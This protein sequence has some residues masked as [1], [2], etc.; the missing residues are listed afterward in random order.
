MFQQNMPREH[1]RILLC[2]FT[3]FTSLVV[4]VEE[5]QRSDECAD[6][7]NP[8]WQDRRQHRVKLQVQYLL[9]TR[10]NM[11]CAQMFSRESLT[12]TQQQQK[13]YFNV[14]R[15]TKVI[16]H[17]YRALGSKPSWLMQLVHSVLWA[18]DVN[19][20]VVDWI[21]GASFAYNLVVENYKDVALQISVLIN[22]L[23]EHGCKLESFHF[24]GVS[25]GAHVAGFVG[26]LFEGK[27]GRITALDPAGP[28][29]K[30]ADTFDRLDSS[31]ALFVD[32]IHTDSDYFGIS[33]P[34]GHL[35]F[36][37]NGGE[38]DQTG[39]SRSRFA[40]I[41]VYFP[42]YG[43]VICDH[44]R[45]LHVYISALNSSCPLIG[46]P[47]SSYED[48]LK[49]RCLDCDVFKGRCPTIGLSKNSGIS[50][51]PVP[52]EQKLFLLT[53]S[54]APFCSHHFLL[55]L[56]VSPLDKSAEVEVTL[57]TGNLGTEKRFRLQ[58]DTTVYRLVLSHPVALCEIDSIKLKNTGNRFYRQSE[59]HVRSVCLSEFP[60]LRREEP[61]CVNNINVRR[62]APW[63]HDFVQVCGVF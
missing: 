20:V 18:E 45:A 44:M 22:Q 62:G 1:L 39:C 48:F 63:S 17:G 58:T 5:T 30:G 31:D 34:V 40:S 29:F 6:L 52:K 11:D 7:N 27:I 54:S 32:A 24:I 21:Y 41:L 3:V 23:Q 12:E 28:M 26:T 25:L 59:V 50:V 43:Y 33:I 15:P 36:F 2:V 42:V 13:S 4:G 57:V 9:L 16:V 55:Q 37:L 61:L 53:T 10:R 8:T 14:S 46:I 56:E 51:S 35:D 47:C 38:P 49:G 60:T 19:V